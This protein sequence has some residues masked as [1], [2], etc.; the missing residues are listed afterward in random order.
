VSDGWLRG[1]LGDA[2]GAPAMGERLDRLAAFANVVVEQISSGA[3]AAPVDYEQDE[4]EW[5]VLLDGR[6]SMVVA[7]EPV[8]LEPGDW[9]FLPARVRHR[10]VETQP[11]TRW[12]AVLATRSGSYPR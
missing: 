8:E 7:G 6:A 5:V 4:D 11:G 2:A 3:L 1:R 10:L 12:L 9:L